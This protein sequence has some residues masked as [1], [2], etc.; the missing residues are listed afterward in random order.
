MI[1]SAVVAMGPSA[2]HTDPA[3]IQGQLASYEQPLPV[4]AQ[5][6]IHGYAVVE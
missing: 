1:S 4:T 2:W 3:V 5:V 6:E